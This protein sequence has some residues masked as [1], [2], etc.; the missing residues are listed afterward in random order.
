MNPVL[1]VPTTSIISTVIPTTTTST[2]DAGG[3]A[4]VQQ[5]A[6]TGAGT[7][8]IY[9]YTTTNSAGV[10][11]AVIDTFTPTYYQSEVSPPPYTGTVLDYS[12]WLAIIGTNTAPAAQA[13]SGARSPVISAG[14]YGLAIAALS[15]MLG[16][17]W[18]VLV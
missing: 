4:P 16:G 10:T 15:G 7:P 1:L 17:A 14:W 13:I 18:L 3:A 12:S 5:P 9:T 6:P 8:T 11:T 2:A